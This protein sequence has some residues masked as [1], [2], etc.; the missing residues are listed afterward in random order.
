MHSIAIIIV[1]PLFEHLVYPLI[2]KAKGSPVSITQ[3]MIAGYIFAIVA[4][5]IAAI[6]VC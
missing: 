6:L 3:K 5:I 2:A 4:A 1:V